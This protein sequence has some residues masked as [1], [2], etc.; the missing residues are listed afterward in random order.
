MN[1][2]PS[3]L[4]VNRG[5]DQGAATTPPDNDA[6]GASTGGGPP[7]AHVRRQHGQEYMQQRSALGLLANLK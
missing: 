3:V 2:N 6:D 1:F 5:H 4:G 7:G